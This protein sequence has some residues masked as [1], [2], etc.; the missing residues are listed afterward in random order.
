LGNQHNDLA[1]ELP[2]GGSR[3]SGIGKEGG[4]HGMLEFNELKMM[5]LEMIE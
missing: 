4:V 5:C 3:E 1:T 2:W